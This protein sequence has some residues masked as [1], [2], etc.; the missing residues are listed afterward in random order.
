M[1][2]CVV[3]PSYFGDEAM[4]RSNGGAACYIRATCYPRVT[5]AIVLLGCGG[6][7]GGGAMAP[8]TARPIAATT[9]AMAPTRD[10]GDEARDG[11]ETATMATATDRGD[12]GVDGDYVPLVTATVVAGVGPGGH[13]LCGTATL[14]EDVYAR[15]L[16]PIA[17]LGTHHTT[18]DMTCRRAGRSVVPLRPRFGEFLPSGVGTGELVLPTGWPDGAGRAAVGVSLHLFNATSDD[19]SGLSGLEVIPAD[20]SEVE[21]TASLSYNGPMGFNIG[22]GEEETVVHETTLAAQTLVGIFPHMH[23]LGTE[24]RAVLRRSGGESVVLYDDEYQFESQEFVP[25]AEIEV[26]SGDILETSCTWINTTKFPVGWGTSSEAE[27]CYSI[28]M[29]YDLTEQ[30]VRR[31]KRQEAGRAIITAPAAAPILPSTRVAVVT[32]GRPVKEEPMRFV[33]GIHVLVTLGVLAAAA[34]ARAQTWRLVWSDEF[35]GASGSFP[36]SANWNYDVG[37]NGGWGN[38]EWEFYCAA[39]SNTPPCS[40]SN[41][42]VQNGSGSLVIRARRVVR[43]L[44]VDPRSPRQFSCS[45]AS[46]G[47]WAVPRPCV[48]AFWMLGKTSAGGWPR[49]AR[50][51][52]WSG[53]STTAPTPQLRPRARLLGPASNG[54][55]RLP[56]GGWWRPSYHIY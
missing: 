35:N 7:N 15:A 23:Q 30:P 48:A 18:V 51:T 50:S 8:T 36:N 4:K 10:D 14:T 49:A 39:G 21:H 46:S 45:T 43:D 17:P 13:L 26:Q 2:R 31:T 47:A 25:L 56:G 16:R 29:S 1:T 5:L 40:A 12:S 55:S 9:A 11:A 28:L 27:M 33:R 19:L 37:N 32:R 6:G 52:S 3:P 42:M 38:G 22:A 53:S 34:P 44:D 54:F 20:P 41:P 24:F